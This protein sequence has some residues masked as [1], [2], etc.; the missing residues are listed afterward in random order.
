[1]MYLSAEPLVYLPEYKWLWVKNKKGKWVKIPNPC[2]VKK[3][4]AFE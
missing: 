3:I 1:M 4:E 2:K